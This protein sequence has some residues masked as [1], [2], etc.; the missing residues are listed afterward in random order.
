MVSKNRRI[1]TAVVNLD[2]AYGPKV[3]EA[4]LRAGLK[5]IFQHRT[6]P[7]FIVAGEDGRGRSPREGLPYGT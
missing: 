3:A 7:Y 2:D 6:L 5:L 1:G 4:A